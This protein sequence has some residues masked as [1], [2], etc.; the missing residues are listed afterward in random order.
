MKKATPFG[1]NIK[2]NP[3]IG[4][5]FIETATRRRL[6]V[7]GITSQVKNQVIITVQQGYANCPKFIQAREVEVHQKNRKNEVI[8]TSGNILNDSFKAVYHKSRYIFCR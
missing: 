6:R 1:E 5:L 7:N 2:D 3:Q 8:T 4:M